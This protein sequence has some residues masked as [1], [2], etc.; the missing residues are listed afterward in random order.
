MLCLN[1]FIVS[2]L[3]ILFQINDVYLEIKVKAL[4]KLSYRNNY[5]SIQ[6]IESK[7]NHLYL[8]VIHT[9]YMHYKCIDK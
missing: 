4:S 7:R 8:L 2:V 3:V 9:D 5:L 1:L 6:T